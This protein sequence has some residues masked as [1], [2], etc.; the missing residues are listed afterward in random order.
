MSYLFGGTNDDLRAALSSTVSDYKVSISAW[1]N[2]SDTT[3]T[4]NPVTIQFTGSNTDSMAIVLRPGGS[5]RASFW[6]S[7]GI[8]QTDQAG[9][10]ITTGTW[11]HVAGVFN[12]SVSRYAYLDGTPSNEHT[13]LK[14]VEDAY[15]RISIGGADGLSLHRDFVGKV[16]EVGFYIGYG[17]TAND[18]NELASGLSPK[19]VASNNLTYYWSLKSTNL[20]D[21]ISGLTLTAQGDSVTYD[22]DHPTITYS[23]ATATATATG[24]VAL[25]ATAAVTA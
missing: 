23:L 2:T 14:N 10:P 16:A 17:L 22:T 18:V 7:G 5:V 19:L 3:I 9:D 20:V 11:Y 12:S 15:N 6:N 8:V 25:S 1:I 24:L 13:V 4:E 21:E